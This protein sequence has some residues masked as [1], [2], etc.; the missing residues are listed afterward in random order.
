MTTEAHKQATDHFAPG[1]RK[2]KTQPTLEEDL[3]AL[4]QR[5]GSLPPRG[6]REEI[7]ED[8]WAPDPEYMGEWTGPTIPELQ[9][10]HREWSQALVKHH[11]MTPE[12]RAEVEAERAA[13]VELTPAWERFAAAYPQHAGNFDQAVAVAQE[14]VDQGQGQVP[15]TQLFQM[16]AE[17][18][19]QGATNE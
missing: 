9:E 7:T 4:S 11:S 19:G 8:V 6:G 13:A 18:L 16:V 14:I 12:E 2:P 1:Q 5:V 3:Q 10:R 15:E 17:R